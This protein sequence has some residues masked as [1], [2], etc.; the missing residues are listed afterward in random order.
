MQR[1]QGRLGSMKS[2][3]KRVKG[4][5][6]GVN[7]RRLILAAYNPE[8]AK[9]AKRSIE[10]ST[11]RIGVVEIWE[12]DLCSYRSVQE[13]AKQAK[14]LN[15]L[16]AVVDNAAVATARF[17]IAEADELT[18]T[19]N[20]ISTFFLA[21][22]LLPKMKQTAQKFHTRP[23]LNIVCTGAIFHTSFPE[24]QSRR[25]FE[26]L[27]D[28]RSA[29]MQARYHISKLMVAMIC[30]EIYAMHHEGSPVIINYSNPG[31]CHSTLLRKMFPG[32]IIMAC[33]ARSAECGSRTVIHALTAG[34]DSHGQ[35]LNDGKV[36]NP[37]HLLLT[38][39]GADIQRRVYKELT[40]K[41]EAIQPGITAS[42]DGRTPDKWMKD[43][44]H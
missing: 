30:R 32:D 34:A 36:K 43:H 10:K 24:A 38:R 5:C 37:P 16:D 21:A 29:R 44:W 18:V 33:L 39:E 14:K 4:A 3:S 26:Q 11:R 31:F 1:R 2:R 9:E 13:F 28:K 22:L 40:R 7:H 35:C 12:L 23:H 8:T 19:I 6:A 25:I 27:N 41:L 17:Q 15:R 42:L 20:V